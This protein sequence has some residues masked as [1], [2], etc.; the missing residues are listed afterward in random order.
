MIQSE[1]LRDRGSFSSQ[2]NNV[3]VEMR[4]V[5]PDVKPHH[6]EFGPMDWGE[7]R[8]FA[9]QQAKTIMGLDDGGEGFMARAV[10]MSRFINDTARF[11]NDGI[12]G[13]FARGGRKDTL[14]GL[15][16]RQVVAHLAGM[17]GLVTLLELPI[18][19]VAA[20]A[21]I[22]GDGD[23]DDESSRRRVLKFVSP[24]SSEYRREGGGDSHNM[25]SENVPLA[26][27]GRRLRHTA[28][29]GNNNG[30]LGLL[31]LL[32]TRKGRHGA[33]AATARLN[34]VLG[35]THAGTGRGRCG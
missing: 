11:L 29:E 13:A 6:G 3:R 9:V 4:M 17:I 20:A 18:V 5:L 1:I 22:D 8:D 33:I 30:V 26:A 7:M 12:G 16:T 23:D 10:P 32:A 15:G 19:S 35:G 28:M 2:L 27:Y 21:S 25:D 14:V 34:G 24:A 31:S